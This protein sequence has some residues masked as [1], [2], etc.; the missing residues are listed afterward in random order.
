MRNAVWSLLP[1]SIKITS[2][3]PCT[4]ELKFCI[5]TGNN[6]GKTCSSLY[7]GIITEN[8]TSLAS[9]CSIQLAYCIIMGGTSPKSSNTANRKGA[10]I[11]SPARAREWGHWFL[12]L[13]VFIEIVLPLDHSDIEH[14]NRNI[15]RTRKAGAG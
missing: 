2:H 1:S 4:H 10:A 14:S 8:S 3:A 12:I 9:K 6:R 15:G 13:P 5:K 11:I 7:A